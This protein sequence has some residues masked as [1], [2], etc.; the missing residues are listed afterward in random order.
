[1]SNNVIIGCD[2]SINKPALCIY[3]NG[4]YEFYSWPFGLS[5]KLKIIYREAGVHLIDRT[6]VK[7]KGSDSS[8][9]M[10]WEV[11][12]AIELTDLIITSLP[13]GNAKNWKI[14]FEGLS[15]G[16]RGN[17]ALQLGGYKYMLMKAFFDESVPFENMFTYA[18][19]T[20]KKTANCAKKGM[21]KKEMIDAFVQDSVPNSL[22]KAIQEN[23]DNFKKKTGSWIDHLD[24]LADSYW[25]IETYQNKLVD[26]I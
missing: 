7:Y 26:S 22:K 4:K 18:P 24:D 3:K 11:K 12:N 17:V 2:F 9:K 6:D 8:E 16:S 25:A 10:R 23:P 5:E 15:F 20:I 14:V 21:G 19:I 13:D 1:M